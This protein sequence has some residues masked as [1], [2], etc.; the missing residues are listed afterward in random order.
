MDHRHPRCDLYFCQAP[1]FLPSDKWPENFL[2]LCCSPPLMIAGHTLVLEAPSM[3]VKCQWMLVTYFAI[4]RLNST[5][6]TD[7]L[8][9][10]GAKSSDFVISAGEAASRSSS[11]AV[12][13][14]FRRFEGRAAANPRAEDNV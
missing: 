13:R 1:F 3:E 11:E 4:N 5:N 2:S 9:K 12:E 10:S 14:I 6:Q 7:S 8:P